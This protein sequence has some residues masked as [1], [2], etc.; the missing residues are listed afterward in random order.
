[1]F[2]SL[3]NNAYGMYLIHYVFVLWLQYVLLNTT[4][5]AIEKGAIVFVGTLALSWI[6]IAAIRRIPAVSRVISPGDSNASV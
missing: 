4:F 1:M 3:H 5:A 2:D 6:I